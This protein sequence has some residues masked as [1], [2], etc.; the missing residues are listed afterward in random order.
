MDLGRILEVN[1]SAEASSFT[2]G[3]CEIMQ[4]SKKL[5]TLVV[6]TVVL[7]CLVAVVRLW[8]R[9]PKP[10]PPPAPPPHQ[11]TVEPVEATSPPP[12]PTQVAVVATFAPASELSAPTPAAL[13]TP[14]PTPVYK[15]Y[16]EVKHLLT[17][18]YNTTTYTIILPYTQ[19]EPTPVG[20]ELPAYKRPWKP[21]WPMPIPPAQPYQ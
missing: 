20:A 3:A 6:A 11:Q 19:T 5:P 4:P 7:L 18:F 21:G 17:G 12:L 1:L 16:Y 2:P 10:F 15:D 8:I 13:S 14:E 9:T